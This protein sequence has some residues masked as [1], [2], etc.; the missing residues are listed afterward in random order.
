MAGGIDGLVALAVVVD[1]AHFLS[2]QLD[3]VHSE[4]VQLARPMLVVILVG[5]YLEHGDGIG[6]QS[7]RHTSVGVPQGSVMVN[8]HIARG[9]VLGEGPMNPTSLE[10]TC[11]GELAYA[12]TR[13]R[14]GVTR[15]PENPAVIP[16]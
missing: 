12:I 1:G 5:S 11:G 7:P 9:R 2:A 13:G 14:W 10:L 16:R 4:I 6:R 8:F 15:I 3:V